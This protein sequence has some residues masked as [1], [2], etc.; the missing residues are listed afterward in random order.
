M[1][2]RWNSAPPTGDHGNEPSSRA[3]NA[4]STRSGHSSLYRA[5]VASAGVLAFAAFPSVANAWSRQAHRV[6]AHLA[7]E[8]LT[9]K[10]KAAVAAIIAQSPAQGTPTCPVASIDDAST[11][12]D[13]VRAFH[14]FDYLAADDYEGVPLCGAAL[15]IRYCPGD[16]CLVDQTRRAEAALMDRAQPPLSRLQALEEVAQFVGDLHDPLYTANNHDH[17]G[18]DDRVIIEGHASTLRQVWETA[19]VGQAVG[20]S[21]PAA[22]AMLRPSVAANAKGPWRDGEPLDWLMESHRLAV[23]Y[24]YGKLAIPPVCGAPAVSQTLSQ[25]YLKGAEPIVREQLVKAAV[26]LASVLN[27]ELN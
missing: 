27:D 20:R 8:Q 13:C 25:G 7:Y 6:I 14:R 9:P 24:V 11:W 19:V 22:E 4:E 26:R 2:T 1:M 23:N 18:G 15:K 21:E 10:A 17:R 12:P 16:Q 5:L 3:P